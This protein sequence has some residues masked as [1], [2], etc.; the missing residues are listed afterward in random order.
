MP[1]STVFKI[2]VSDILVGRDTVRVGAFVAPTPNH[3]FQRCGELTLTQ[4][5]ARKLKNLVEVPEVKYEYACMRIRN[6]DRVQMASPDLHDDRH[7]EDCEEDVAELV[8]VL[9]KA[10]L[11]GQYYS[12]VVA[13]RVK[14]GEIEF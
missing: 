11:E 5:E 6:H 7:W 10:A 14:A 2:K 12:F 4:E 1:E 8:D 9:N 3:T 13:K